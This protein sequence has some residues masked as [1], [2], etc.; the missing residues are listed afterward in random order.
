MLRHCSI[1]ELIEVRNGHGS[2]GA[3]THVGECEECRDEL[4]KLHQRVASLKALPS[5]NAPRN[6]W[7][8]V[9]SR[10]V[11]DRRRVWWLRGGWAAAAT[12]ALLVGGNAVMGGPAA[13]EESMVAQRGVAPLPPQ[14]LVVPSAPVVRSLVVQSR[15]LDEALE[16]LTA[17]RRV[18]NGLTALAIADLEDRILVI[19][20]RLLDARREVMY[21][22]EL[23]N[24]LR[25]R[26]L[27]MDELINTHAR[28]ATYVGF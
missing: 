7:P 16:V 6:R 13:L 1:E 25:Q 18:M 2:Y 17:E 4:D 9:R 14:M 11:A 24:L 5:L 8:A 21:R 27:L 20:T 19:D 10:L 15:Y 26:V 28:S 12:I 23:L 22:R 3:R